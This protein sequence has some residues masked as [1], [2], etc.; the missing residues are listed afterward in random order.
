[1]ANSQLNAALEKIRDFPDRPVERYA[2]AECFVEEKHA[3][4]LIALAASFTT[5][6]NEKGGKTLHDRAEVFDNHTGAGSPHDGLRA[7]A[8]AWVRSLFKEAS[9]DAEVERLP[10]SESS[11]SHTS[12]QFKSECLAH[13]FL[14]RSDVEKFLGDAESIRWSPY[15]VFDFCDDLLELFET[16]LLWCLSD[17]LAGLR[18]RIEVEHLWGAFLLNTSQDVIYSAN[19][20]RYR[21]LRDSLMWSRESV[22]AIEAAAEDLVATSPVDGGQTPMKA[23][24]HDRGGKPPGEAPQAREDAE[25]AVENAPAS[26]DEAEKPYWNAAKSTLYLGDKP[27]KELKHPAKNVRRVLAEFERLGWPDQMPDPLR[28]VYHKTPKR[29][30]DT[31]FQLNAKHII[32]DQMHFASD[33]T[34]EGICWHPGPKL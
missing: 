9:P 21:K 29:L 10:A 7:A 20:P 31:I 11:V 28:G 17:N 25:A 12:M 1:M 18:Q 27:I 13:G 34:G 3:E 4:N 6:L 23:E 8:Y 26:M 24:E 15:E 2:V 5:V 33:H 30:N 22:A 19:P 16:Q 14:Y 32:P